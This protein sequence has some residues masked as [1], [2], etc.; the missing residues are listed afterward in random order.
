M[1]DSLTNEDDSV[2]IQ[3]SY[4]FTGDI[5]FRNDC[6]YSTDEAMFIKFI[7]NKWFNLINDN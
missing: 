3:L 2:N 5:I 7:F 6:L 1:T 4:L